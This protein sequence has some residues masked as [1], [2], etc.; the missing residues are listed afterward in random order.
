MVKEVRKDQVKVKK[1]ES[2]GDGGNDSQSGAISHRCSRDQVSI[3]SAALTRFIVF[4]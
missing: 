1:T 4:W 3:G 2:G